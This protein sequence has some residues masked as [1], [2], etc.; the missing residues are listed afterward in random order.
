MYPPSE[1]SYDAG[2][3]N[4]FGDYKPQIIFE[5]GYTIRYQ[6]DG[7]LTVYDDNDEAVTTMGKQESAPL[8]DLKLHFQEDGN[9]VAYN[10]DE[11]YWHTYTNPSRK[12]ARLICKQDAPYMLLLDE[13]DN[14]VWCLTEENP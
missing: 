6:D 10:K 5:N 9:L 7:N 2:E 8:A 12:A 4:W 14:Q 3:L 1:V 13:N 11:A